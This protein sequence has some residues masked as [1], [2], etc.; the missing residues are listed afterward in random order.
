[1]IHLTRGGE[2]FLFPERTGVA[3]GD[4]DIIIIEHQPVKSHALRVIGAQARH[5]GRNVAQY[6]LPEHLDGGAVIAQPVHTAVAKLGKVLEAEL[7]C[8]FV[9]HMDKLVE[10]SVKLASMFAERFAQDLHRLAPRFTVVV[11]EIAQ[12]RRTRE[13]FTAKLKFH[14]RHQL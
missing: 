7:F 10:D 3:A 13:L 4:D 2:N 9:A 12:Q 1:M 5:R 8:N 14:P 11:L 6:I